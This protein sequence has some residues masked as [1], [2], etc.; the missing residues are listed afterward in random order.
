MQEVGRLIKNG[1]NIER[2]GLLIGPFFF[3]L[4]K[5]APGKQSV[6]SAPHFK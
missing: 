1:T 3:V 5:G 2:A 6:K 4:K